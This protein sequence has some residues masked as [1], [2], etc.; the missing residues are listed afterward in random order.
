MRL[1]NSTLAFIKLEIWVGFKLRSC[2]MFT[3]KLNHKKI[4]LPY[5]YKTYNIDIPT[6]ISN[7]SL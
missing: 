3:D 6:S 1:S 2:Q 7:I 4:K 5:E